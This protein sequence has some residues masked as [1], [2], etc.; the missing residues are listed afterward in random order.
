MFKCRFLRIQTMSFIQIAHV[1]CKCDFSKTH[2]QYDARILFRP[3][4]FRYTVESRIQKCSNSVI[5]PESHRQIVIRNRN[6]PSY[7][8]LSCK[9]ISLAKCF[10][11][12][13]F[14]SES[15]GAS[16]PKP[17]R[18]TWF[19]TIESDGMHGKYNSFKFYFSK[20]GSCP[21]QNV[22]KVIKNQKRSSKSDDL[23]R[24][25]RKYTY[26]STFN[27]GLKNIS[28]ENIKSCAKQKRLRIRF[29]KQLQIGSF[30]CAPVISKL[31]L[32]SRD[33]HRISLR[34]AH[35]TRIVGGGVRF[36][37]NLHPIPIYWQFNQK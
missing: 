23:S 7:L 12:K 33:G 10:F 19:K 20:S 18:K 6:F 22:P 3:N 35:L 17:S 24:L 21:C 26:K 27:L 9:G 11:I 34:W 36:L 30:A 5:K 14:K 31:I 25:K 1:S 16:W 8:Q 4:S 2:L 32:G 37:S 15:R 29:L 13:F 28:P